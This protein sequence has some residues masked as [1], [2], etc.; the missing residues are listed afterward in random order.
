MPDASTRA[1]VRLL[2]VTFLVAGLAALGIGLNR[3]FFE[4]L[5]RG[6]GATPHPSVEANPPERS[7]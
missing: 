5:V 6:R 1:Q 2:V 7:R 4:G 3:W